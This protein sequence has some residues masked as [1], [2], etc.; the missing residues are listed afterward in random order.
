MLSFNSNFN[1]CYTSAGTRTNTVLKRILNGQ[2]NMLQEQTYCK[3]DRKLAIGAT[4]LENKIKDF[5]E[6]I[7]IRKKTG[8]WLRHRK[9]TAILKNS[10]SR[11]S[12][13]EA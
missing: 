13:L 5:E 1:K 7:S 10:W 2:L 8:K 4:L 11:W 9:A 12:E 3:P 6:S